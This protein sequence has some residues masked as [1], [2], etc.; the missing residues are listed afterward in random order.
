MAVECNGHSPTENCPF[1]CDGYVTAEAAGQSQ[2][3]YSGVGIF[4]RGRY[5]A[6]AGEALAIPVDAK[7]GKI[8]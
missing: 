3:L 7:E 4:L 6:R 8:R 5:H 1:G 2:R